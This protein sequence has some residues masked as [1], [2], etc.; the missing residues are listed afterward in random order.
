MQRN[1]SG[2]FGLVCLDDQAGGD[3]DVDEL[4]V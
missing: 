4:V 2:L 3:G 1:Q